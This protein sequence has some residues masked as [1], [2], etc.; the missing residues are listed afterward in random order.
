MQEHTHLSTTSKPGK[1]PG[2]V[3]C[4][5][6]LHRKPFSSFAFVFFKRV[7]HR[8]LFIFGVEK[9]SKLVESR[10]GYSFRESCKTFEIGFLF[11][12]LPCSVST[13]WM[14]LNT[15]SRRLSTSMGLP[16]VNTGSWLDQSFPYRRLVFS[17]RTSSD[18]GCSN[19]AQR[20]WTQDDPSVVV[21][22]VSSKISHILY[23]K[24]KT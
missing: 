23:S 5:T 4:F 24:A 22:Q 15:Q 11:Y 12:I 19:Q 1:Y 18:E 9:G 10:R 16:S 8:G 14:S 21:S 7:V 13:S 3:I 6:S 2:G 20:K 17:V